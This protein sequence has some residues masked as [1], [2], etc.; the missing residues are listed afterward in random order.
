[1]RQTVGDM[2]GGRHIRHQR[3][4]KDKKQMRRKVEDEA[5]EKQIRQEKNN[6]HLV[7][8]ILVSRV[9]LQH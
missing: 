7:I 3:R 6:I 8:K 1:M 2:A 5:G 9:A 4:T